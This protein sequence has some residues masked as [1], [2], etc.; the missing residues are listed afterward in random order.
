MP[1][2]EAALSLL[3]LSRYQFAFTVMFHMLFP[4]IT[5]GLS[6]FLCVVYGM[7]WR[8]RSAV[9]LQMFRFW[10][11]IF[12]VGFAIGV[13]AGIV[14]AFQ[15]GL[16]WGVFAAAAGP[17]QGP[18]LG[19]EVV[20]AFFV[21]AGFIGIL[22]YGDGRVKP[23]TMFVATVMV[24]IGTLLS[25]TWI[26]ANNSWMQTPS[27]FEVH[28]GRFEPTDWLQVIF[29]PSFLWRWWHMLAAVLIS[30]SFFLAGLGSWYLV[31][32]RALPFARRTVSIGLGMAAI[33]IPVQVFLGDQTAGH[34]LPLQLSKL[35]AVEGNWTG[36]GHGN[37]TAYV[38]FAI[39]DQQAER[40]IWQLDI[41]CL[42]SAIVRDL[43]C[44]TGNPGLDLTAPQDRPLMAPVFWGF[45]VMF[46]SA[47]WMFGTAFYATILRLRGKLWTARRFHRYL[48]WAAPAGF[49]AILGGWVTAETGRQPW[50]VFG[51]LRTADAVSHLAPGAVLFSVVGFALLYLV[52][53]VAYIAYIV[54]TMRIGPERDAP[55]VQPAETTPAHPVPA[56]GTV[57]SLAAAGD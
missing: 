8:T 20:T 4:S 31:K 54:H 3:T 5:V 44:K 6:I 35:E 47:L 19:M 50:V 29:S 13:V 11:R 52:M 27:G 16:N 24:T 53:A 9:Y 22:L 18:L 40:N 48:L 28:N 25:S 39:P 51:Y 43:S 14:M 55:V 10:R 56:H 33:V 46:L 21:E 37:N 30:A 45:R 32:G 49:L 34:E 17:I 57:A 42:S 36:D 38:L 23:P 15:F 1:G 12:A 7:Y 26:I 2:Q 41:P